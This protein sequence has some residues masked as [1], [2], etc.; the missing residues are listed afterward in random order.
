[1]PAAPIGV[2]ITK[3]SG[4]GV[5]ITSDYW[6]WDCRDDLEEILRNRDVESDIDAEEVEGDTIDDE[7]DTSYFQVI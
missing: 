7:F 6:K 3:D 4:S 2:C 5:E 1:M